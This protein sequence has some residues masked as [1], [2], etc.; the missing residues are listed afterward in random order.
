M[1]N[2]CDS[3]IAIIC[4]GV[5]HH[6][7]AARTIAFVSYLFIRDAL[8]CARATA[9]RTVNRVVGHV[10]ALRVRYGFAKTSVCVY[11][12]AAR[13]CRNRNLFN[14][15]RKHLAALGVQRALLMLD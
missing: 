11:V 8:F 7:H 1:P 12:A 13:A 15:L 6:G 14:Q 4:H 10:R 3:A 2:L 5:N 9:Y